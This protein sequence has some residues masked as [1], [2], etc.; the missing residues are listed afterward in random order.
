MILK[1]PDP[2]FKVAPDGQLLHWASGE[3]VRAG[4]M[5]AGKSYRFDRSGANLTVPTAG[6]KRDT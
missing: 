5:V 4:D 2:D 6:E 1:L 3:P